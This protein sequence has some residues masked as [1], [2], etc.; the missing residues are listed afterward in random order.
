MT[1]PVTISNFN[2]TPAAVAGIL[3][4][5]GLSWFKAQ[6]RFT[7]AAKEGS[8]AAHRRPTSPKYQRS[9]NSSGHDKDLCDDCYK[10]VDNRRVKE[11]SRT[12][13]KEPILECFSIPAL[14]QLGIVPEISIAPPTTISSHGSQTSRATT[15]DIHIMHEDTD[16]QL[17]NRYDPLR[18]GSTTTTTPA[19]APA[20]TTP[21]MP[22]RPCNAIESI[23]LVVEYLPLVGSPSTTTTNTNQPMLIEILQEDQLPPPLQKHNNVVGSTDEMV[24]I[25]DVD[26]TF[27]E[28]YN[29][30]LTNAEILSPPPP[31]SPFDENASSS[32]LRGEL[33]TNSNA[34]TS[35]DGKG[36]G[37]GDGVDAA[38][39]EAIAQWAQEQAAIEEHRLEK[40]RRSQVRAQ[41]KDELRKTHGPADHGA[42]DS[43]IHPLVASASATQEAKLPRRPVDG[44]GTTSH[45][46]ST[47]GLTTISSSTPLKVLQEEEEHD[48]DTHTNFK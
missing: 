28:Q 38:K 26:D 8:R 1:F 30:Q 42:V 37:G 45:D 15:S 14:Q 48:G 21:T 20:T 17:Y 12:R 19:T 41:A 25:M 44:S 43:S 23:F 39:K 33:Q 9:I 4:L 2:Y 34:L 10:N 36:S 11:E 47:F 40:Q 3:I 29:P 16:P 35:T 6:F 22:T 13:V 32:L 7:G 24:D 5:S 46:R 27:D 18:Y 31:H